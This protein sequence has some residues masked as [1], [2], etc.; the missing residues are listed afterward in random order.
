M[1]NATGAS[2]SIHKRNYRYL[3]QVPPA[4]DTVAAGLPQL[5]AKAGLKT[6]AIIARDEKMAQPMDELL[7]SEV[8]KAGMELRP[9]QYYIL[10][11]YRGLAP[12]A[13]Q[14]AKLG[15]DVIV[16]PAS[17]RESADILRG[18]KA[19]G[20]LPGLFVARGATDPEF[21]RQLGQDAEYSIGLSSYE[22]RLPTPGNADFVKA[23][24]AKYKAD[25]DFQ[26]ACGWAAGQVIDAAVAAA[27]TFDQE[28]LRSAFSKLET[29]TVLGGYKVDD[30]GTQLAAQSY[31]VQILRGKREVVWPEALRGAAAVVPAPGW[32]GRTLLK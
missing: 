24:R 18:F 25:P 20:V 31:V 17:P 13:R 10:D 26:A 2:P 4:S 32:A 30:V 15:I 21:I 29:G 11:V 6:M 9:Q 5:A 27:G 14:L 16:A 12:F 8:P 3:F 23:Y 28:K 1:V 7:R 19:A 22:A